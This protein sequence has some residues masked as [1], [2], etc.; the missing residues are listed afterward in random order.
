M[1]PAGNNTTFGVDKKIIGS[2]GSRWP[3]DEKIVS[4][5]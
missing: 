4:K 5:M 3:I 1:S 2:E